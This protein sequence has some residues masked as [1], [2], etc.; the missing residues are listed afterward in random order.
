MASPTMIREENSI[1]EKGLTINEL[2]VRVQDAMREG[3]NKISAVNAK[4]DQ[5]FNAISSCYRKIVYRE[6]VI[7]P[8]G[9]LSVIEHVYS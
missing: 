7:E 1:Q 5:W 2:I 9:E 4:Y 8:I 6:K 3:E